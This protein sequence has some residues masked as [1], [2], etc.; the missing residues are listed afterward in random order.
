[1]SQWI[2]AQKNEWSLGVGVCSAPGGEL[3]RVSTICLL[4][5]TVQEDIYL[6]CGRET[7]MQCELVNNTI[8]P[9]TYATAC[10]VISCSDLA[11]NL[12][13]VR[14]D[15]YLNPLLLDSECYMQLVLNGSQREGED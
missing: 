9:G 7:Q 3:G 10:A 11:I 14:D 13:S 5:S 8:T 15:L 12:L 2:V 4:F 6:Q 1:M